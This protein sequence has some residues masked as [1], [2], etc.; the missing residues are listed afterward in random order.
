MTLDKFPTAVKLSKYVIER[1]GWLFGLKN[2]SVVYHTLT[3]EEMAAVMAFAGFPTGYHHWTRGKDFLESLESVKKGRIPY[4]MVIHSREPTIGYLLDRNSLLLQQL[5]VAH[6]CGHADFFACNHSFV[7]ATGNMLERMDYQ[8][9]RLDEIRAEHGEKVDRFLENVLVLSTMIDISGEEYRPVES[10]NV[11]GEMRRIKLPENLPDYLEDSINDEEHLAAEKKRISGE[12]SFAA[13][14]EKGVVFPI[15]PTRDVLGFLIEHATI[16]GWQREVIG[17]VREESRFLWSGARTKTMNEGWATFWHRRIMAEL[18]STLNIEATSFSKFDA[19]VVANP[20]VQTNPYRLGVGL[21]EDIEF[22]WN[23]GRHGRIFEDCS[24]SSIRSN[25]DMFAIF[26]YLGDRYGVGSDYH[27]SAWAEASVFIE[28]NR[29][30]W[31]V[32][33]RSSHYVQS[34]LDYWEAENHLERYRSLR[35]K[36]AVFEKKVGYDHDRALQTIECWHH[37]WLDSGSDPDLLWSVNQLDEKIAQ[38]EERLR[39]KGEISLLKPSSDG[40][41]VPEAWF[42]WASGYQPIEL[43]V[44]IR[45]M[46]E[47]MED[48]TDTEFIRE[49]MTDDFIRSNGYH[50]IG[51]EKGI[52]HPSLGNE[53]FDA[54]V[55][56]SIDGDRV[57]KKICQQIWNVGSPLLEV[58]D[59]NYGKAGGL[60]LRHVHDGR[61]LDKASVEDALRA[62]HVVFGGVGKVFIETFVTTWPKRKSWQETWVPAG[63]EKPKKE[64]I[65]RKKVMFS[66]DGHRVEQTNG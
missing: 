35:D 26:K 62:L 20:G 10:I 8:A 65:I 56:K 3:A 14:V 11:S 49:F 24:T 33:F 36:V 53:P 52:F 17:M 22:R 2:P 23:T 47:V 58:A 13:E 40:Y 28:I 31:G 34:F 7:A 15:H 54:Y 64:N 12:K 42:T 29:K 63:H 48:Y 21:W 59:G 41:P 1:V 43:G 66:F 18:G 4:E 37:V 6:V 9:K 30:K 60:Y 61:D 27:L 57:R 25:W 39:L 16:E 19:G 50:T 55:V 32:A 5:V 44:G 51:T 45:K 46:R 38:S